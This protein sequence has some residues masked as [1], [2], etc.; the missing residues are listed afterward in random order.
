KVREEYSRRRALESSRGLSTEA[1]PGNTW[2][3]I[4]PTNGAGRA[5]AIAVHPTLAGTVYIGA[6]GGGGWKTTDAGRNWGSLTESINDLS[7]GAVALAPSDPDTIYLGT[8]EGGLAIDFIPGIGFLKSTD[9]GASWIFPT[10]VLA[11]Q[12]FRFSVNPGDSQDLVAGT[13]KGGWRSTDGGSNWTQVIDS[14]RYPFVTD[15]VRHPN[16]PDVLYAATWD[17]EQWCARSQTCSSSSPRVLKSTDDG[18]TWTEKSS[19]IPLS[20]PTTLVDRMSLAISQS[21]PAIIYMATALFD[22]A[23]GVYTSHVFKSSDA[24]E[25]WNDLPGVAQSSNTNVNRFMASQVWYNNTIVVSPVDPNVVIAGGTLYVRTTDGGNTWS[26]APFMFTSSSAHVDAHDLRYQGAAL[27]I[28]NDG[29][30]WT[31]QDDG[32]TSVA[33]NNNLVTRQYYGVGI[34]SVNRN[35]VLGGAQDNGTTRRPDSGGTEWTAVI[36]GD[37]FQ[38]GVIDTV[39]DYS[40]GT[41]QGAIIMR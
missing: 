41:V 29:G 17:G 2:T 12:F 7:V 25:T 18:M 15:I 30:I 34:D 26:V 40:Y 8:G 27:Y 6:A 35:R 38:C 31:S 20:T 22:G 21:N 37:G 4:G 19:G 3:S 16:K 39:P 5:T 36:G 32:V 28:A 1:I 11:S 13:N 10:S 33:R 24:G 14:V 9:A 23:S